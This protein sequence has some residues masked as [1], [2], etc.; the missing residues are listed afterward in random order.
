MKLLIITQKVDMNDSVLGFF[1]RW[2]ELFARQSKKVT[3]ICL[4]EGAHL[5]PDNV[6]VLSLGKEEGV[7][8]IQY[9]Y[10]LY[11]YVISKRHE[12]DNV[13]VH[14]NPE[15]IVLV[16]W[17]WKLLSKQVALWYV[18]KSVNLKLRIAGWFADRIFTTTKEACRLSCQTIR[19]V[20]H[21]I[22]ME[23][24]KTGIFQENATIAHIGRITPIKHIE[25]IAKVGQKLNMQVHLYGDAGA[26]DAAYAKGLKEMFGNIVWHGP[27]SFGDLP[28]KY[29]LHQCT[30][31]AAPTGGMDK[32][33]I[34]SWARG[35]PA[36]TR[37]EAFR[38]M[39][40]ADADVFMYTSEHELEEKIKAFFA[41]D[42][43]E[44]IIKRIRDRIRDEYDLSLLIQNIVTDS[45]Y[46][47]H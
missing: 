18:H 23:I 9:V 4:E 41:R 47:R 35:V 39:L 28:D 33:V 34:E 6:E 42:N 12:Y 21:G 7:S 32:S 14:M 26:G 8:R 46:V 16:G 25:L 20:G 29:T 31:N 45:I 24:F 5:L 43:A 30:V 10:R 11:T 15:Y 2:I 22:D 37:N 13:F 3:V 17:L 1:H 19:A 36:F 40:G 44:E 38:E 27:V